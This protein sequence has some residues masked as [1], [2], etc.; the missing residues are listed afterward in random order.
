[1]TL[2][3]NTTE[4]PLLKSGLRYS[5]LSLFQKSMPVLESTQLYIKLVQEPLPRDKAAGDVRLA[6]HVCLL[7]I[8][9]LNGATPP[10]SYTSSRRYGTNLLLYNVIYLLVLESVEDHLFLCRKGRG[11]ECCITFRPAGRKIRHWNCANT[12]PSKFCEMP[13][14]S[15]SWAMKVILPRIQHSVS[16]SP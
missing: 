14:W 12:S 13:L 15:F 2:H 5:Y 1:L 7:Q 3:V 9:R 4:C 10:V 8:L 16:I 6:T 11:E